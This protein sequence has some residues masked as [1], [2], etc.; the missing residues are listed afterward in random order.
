KA[1]QIGKQ[2]RELALL[3]G[4]DLGVALQRAGQLGRKELLELHAS[5]GRVRFARQPCQASTDGAGQKLHELSLQRLD[6]PLATR[7]RP[8]VAG[9][10]DNPDDLVVLIEDGRTHNGLDPH[11]ALGGRVIA[12]SLIKR[13]PFA[14]NLQEYALAELAVVAAGRAVT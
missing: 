5:A 3:G 10:I 1:T 9:A 2:E 6:S 4:E 8:H 13:P 14:E 7:R 11:Q 12:E